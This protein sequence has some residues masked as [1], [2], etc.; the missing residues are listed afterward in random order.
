MAPEL[1]SLYI[2]SWW[3]IF[4]STVRNA[5]SNWGLAELRI[6][7]CTLETLMCCKKPT[8]SRKVE[9]SCSFR[10]NKLR[11]WTE[12]NRHTHTSS[13]FWHGEIDCFN[14]DR[15]NGDSSRYTCS[16]LTETASKFVEDQWLVYRMEQART[17]FKRLL[18]GLVKCLLRWALKKIGSVAWTQL[19][20]SSLQHKVLYILKAMFRQKRSEVF[21]V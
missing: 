16:W 17:P 19:G 11:T 6:S 12:R 9:D 13:L 15:A 7:N 4:K 21:T 5:G 2:N 1:P 20:L 8:L 3:N 18:K 10:A 14:Q